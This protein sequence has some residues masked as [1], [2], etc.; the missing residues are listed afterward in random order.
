[1]KSHIQ[2]IE[3]GKFS[4]PGM[5]IKVRW[6]PQGVSDHRMWSARSNILSFS[7]TLGD[8][9]SRAKASSASP[10]CRSTEPLMFRPR[11]AVWSNRLHKKPVLTVSSYFDADLASGA[12]NATPQEMIVRDFSVLEMMQMLHDEVRMP[13]EESREL[14]GAIGDIIRI[15]LSRLMSQR[16]RAPS[17]TGSCRS[18]DIAMIQELIGATKGH[19]PTTAQLAMQLNTSRRSVLRLFKAATGTSPSRYMEDMR[20]EN[21]KALLAASRMSMKQIA[22]EAGYATASHFS[23]RFHQLTGLT[24]SLFR[25]GARRRVNFE[26]E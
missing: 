18:V 21:A 9:V 23:A 3:L 10:V 17:L 4:V 6:F 8:C 13:G 22:Q 11:S 12:L 15:K 1:M 20:I 7:R 16:A 5:R 24:P 14:V 2:C 26:S 19:L 25:A